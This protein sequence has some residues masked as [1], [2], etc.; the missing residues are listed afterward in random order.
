[1]NDQK[2]DILNPSK[3]A[4]AHLN[5]ILDASVDVSDEVVIVDGNV[6][7][8]VRTHVEEIAAQ[9]P[10]EEIVPEL[11]S[12][13]I[14][15]ARTEE[16]VLVQTEI[17][18]STRLLLITKDSRI[19]EEG[20]EIHRR[21]T[22]LRNRF[23]EIHIVL[24]NI[25]DTDTDTENVTER[26]FEN[27]WLYPTNSSAPWKWWFHAYTIIKSQL[28]FSGGFRADIVIADDPAV[29]GM[30]GRYVSQ[31][32]NRPFLLH[33]QE[34]FF[35][36]QFVNTK[37]Y[38]S[39][40]DWCVAYVLE[41]VTHVRT[42]TE[43]QRLAVIHERP[44]LENTVEGLPQYYPLDGWKNFPPTDTLRKFYPQF[45]FTMLHVSTMHTSS[46]TAS[47]IAGAAR[48]MLRY[49]SLGL[50][51]VGNGPLRSRLEAN[52]I[53]LHVQKQV[54]FL[55]MPEEILSYITSA[56]LC[57]HM[58]D[59]VNDDEFLLKSA[60]VK[61]PLVANMRGLGGRLFVENESACL[62]EPGD[63]KCIA[64]SI[65]RYLNENQMR[66]HFALNAFESTLER[67]DQNYDAY[68]ESYALSIERSIVLES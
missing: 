65:N 31:K 53:A 49:P 54:E 51:I 55:S 15:E 57:I 61:V 48:I 7:E 41:H 22:D 62:C 64:D 66:T 32:Y 1:M 3:R 8:R 37:K 30:V 42:D 36:R 40:Y 5:T 23:L 58:S 45:K 50:V 44:E 24:L 47:V 10:V 33:I 52:V 25:A 13:K 67:V 35:D 6:A 63:V 46:H 17:R 2:T 29:A 39:F 26:L 60:M 34:D 14:T 21:I 12:V 28:E 9:E 38:P 56:N 59:D 27:V 19:H 68:L 11:P 16:S 20:S 18:Q 4:A 43:A